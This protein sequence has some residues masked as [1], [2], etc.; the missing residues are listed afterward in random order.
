MKLPLPPTEKGAGAAR[1]SSLDV[2]APGFRRRWLR[3][4]G[5][6]RAG[7]HEP[8]VWETVR[9]NERQIYLY[10]FGR[11][12]DDG[13]GVVTNVY[14]A[15]DGWHFYGL[16]LDVICRRRLWKATPSFWRALQTACAQEGLRWGGDWNMNGDCGDERLLDRPHVQFGP[17]MRVSPSP[18]AARLYAG[19]GRQAVWAVVGAA[20]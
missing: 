8:L 3:V 19:G 7:G 16:A 14:E 13:R 1:V 4:D 5:W 20:E 18:S 9:T 10:R 2:L 15:D 17:P 12:W 11:E 6:M